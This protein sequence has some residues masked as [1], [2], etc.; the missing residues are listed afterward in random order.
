MSTC[1]APNVIQ[2]T[3]FEVQ[4]P[5]SLSPAT[6]LNTLSTWSG[7]ARTTTTCDGALLDGLRRRRIASRV[8]AP[9]L[10]AAALAVSEDLITDTAGLVA[11]D[12]FFSNWKKTL[13]LL[14]YY[15]RA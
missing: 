12:N 15:F 14:R 7:G 8:A 9:P 1:S 13:P 2:T 4:S 3:L 5:S 10:V 6:T 11:E